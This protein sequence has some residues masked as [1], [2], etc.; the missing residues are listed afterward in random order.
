MNKLLDLVCFCSVSVLVFQM[1]FVSLGGYLLACLG[2]TVFYG[3]WNV[4]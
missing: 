2:G 1:Y 3:E 4:K